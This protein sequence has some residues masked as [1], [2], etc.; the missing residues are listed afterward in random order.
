MEGTL[1]QLVTT[2]N[3]RHRA[4]GAA[5][6]QQWEKKGETEK[7]WSLANGKEYLHTRGA[8]L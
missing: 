8:K 4:S 7:H 3:K 6:S 5:A 1:N 2:G